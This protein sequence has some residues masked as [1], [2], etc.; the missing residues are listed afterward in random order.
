MLVLGKAFPKRIVISLRW[1]SVR[2]DETL[3][4]TDGQRALREHSHG[5]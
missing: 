4:L 5:R 2:S 1:V 3:L